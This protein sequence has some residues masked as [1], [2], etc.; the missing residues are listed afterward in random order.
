MFLTKNAS[1]EGLPTLKTDESPSPRLVGHTNHSMNV[2]DT[3]G[4]TGIG[5]ANSPPELRPKVPWS[6]RAPHNLQ[7]ALTF[8]S[9]GSKH[10]PHVQA[11]GILG[12]R[13]TILFGMVLPHSFL[14]RL[15]TRIFDQEAIVR[16]HICDQDFTISYRGTS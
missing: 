11:R 2:L 12:A 14:Y 9:G 6:K 3:P 1:F 10:R 15:A 5:L 13:K 4:P 8:R 7:G 16:G